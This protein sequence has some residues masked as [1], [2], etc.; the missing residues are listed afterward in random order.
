VDSVA[1]ATQEQTHTLLE[2][3]PLSPVA[4]ERAVPQLN[5]ALRAEYERL[6]AEAKVAAERVEAVDRIV[7]RLDSERLRY[8]GLET[9][10][11]TP[12]FFTAAIHSLESGQRFDRHLHNGDPLTGRTTHVPAGRPARGAPPFSWEASA[13]DALQPLPIG[14]VP[15]DYNGIEVLGVRAAPTRDVQTPWTA[16]IGTDGLGGR[17]GVVLI[18][19]TKREYFRPKTNS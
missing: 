10:L 6:F 12:W 17:N 11:G 16:E 19:A 5:P 15:E 9:M 3:G 1:D 13:Q 4:E 2:Q 14:I 18:G 7:D 8:A